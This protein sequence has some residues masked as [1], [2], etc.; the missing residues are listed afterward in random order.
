M[1]PVVSIAPSL[2]AMSAADVGKVSRLESRMRDMEQVPIHTTHHFHG[3]L[4]ARTIRIPQGV[5]ITG[6][7]IRI[8]TLLIVSG[9]VTVFA[10]GEPMELQGYHILPG[11]A[12]RKQVFVA[13][14]DTD[15]TMVFPSRAQ[16][17]EEAEAEF[18]G[19][20]DFLMSREQSDDTIIFTGE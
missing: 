17:V 10:G 13:H 5:A 11:S 2:P 8:P 20:V 6:A 7:L 9:H 14:A 18:T 4:Y 1:N 16:T 12:G 3:G 19:E 15:L